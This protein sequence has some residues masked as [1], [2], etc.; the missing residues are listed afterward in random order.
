MRGRGR[1]AIVA[2]VTLLGGL[3]QTLEAVLGAVYLDLG[4]GAARELIEMVLRAQGKWDEVVKKYLGRG[5]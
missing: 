2:A 5:K 1:L 3:S 4:L